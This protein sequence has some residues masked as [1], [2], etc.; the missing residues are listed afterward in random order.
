[1]S[2]GH[3]DHLDNVFEAMEIQI[4]IL[5]ISKQGRNN[6]KR[7]NL[8]NIIKIQPRFLVIWAYFNHFFQEII[9]I[10]LVELRFSIFC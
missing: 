1:M 8:C 9:S 7:Q 10:H 6:A 5:E 2:H 4:Y 3:V